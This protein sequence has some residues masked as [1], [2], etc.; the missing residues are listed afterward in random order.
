MPGLD[1]DAIRRTEDAVCRVERTS[2]AERATSLNTIGTV[3]QIV[4]VTS[5]T[6]DGNGRYPGQLQEYSVSGDSWTDLVECR[7]EAIGVTPALGRTAAIRVGDDGTYPVFVAT[8]G[9]GSGGA[10]GGITVEEVDGSPSYAGIGT[11]RFDQTDGFVLS[12]PA[13]GIARVDHA[14]ATDT[15]RGIVNTAVQVYGGRKRFVAD[16]T[17]LSEAGVTATNVQFDDIIDLGASMPWEV[18]ID[19]AEVQTHAGVSF[20]SGAGQEYGFFYQAE[21]H[22]GASWSYTALVLDAYNP[23]TSGERICAYLRTADS[24][25]D[26]PSSSGDDH[27][28]AGFILVGGAY[29]YHDGTD[30]HVGASATASGLVFKAGLY[31]SGSVSITSAGVSDFA[32]AVDDRVAAML[33]AGSNIT[34]T[35][36]DGANTLT[37]ASSGGVADGDK[38]DITVSSSGTV[39]TIDTNVVSDAKFRQSAALSVVGRSVNSVGNVADITASAAYQ[40]LRCNTAGTAIGFGTIDIKE[41]TGSGVLPVQHGGTGVASAT[42]YAVICGGTTSTGAWQ[43]VASVGTSGQVLTS[44][45]AGALPSFQNPATSG[46]VT[47]VNLTA[48]A[49]GITVSG[50]PITTSGSITLALADDLAALEALAGTNNIYYRSAANTWTSVTIGSGLTF[51]G[52]TLSVS[53]ATA[54]KAWVKFAG[55]SGTIAASHNVTSVSRDSAGV[56]TITWDTDFASANYAVFA[57][58][59]ITAG[60]TYGAY[61]GVANGSQ[62]A[63]SVQIKFLD[64]AGGTIDYPNVYVVAFG[65]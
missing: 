40:V 1:I 34:L 50:G 20:G 56:Y 35:Y 2:G 26:S 27:G 54:A 59:E 53:A 24:G 28:E 42:A 13:T 14:D 48:P 11:L 25:G 23:P 12:Q 46:T 8:V 36:D 51:S 58:V 39:W 45:G 10:A 47:S 52:G 62:A 61:D 32:E 29:Q 33:V 65:S 17:D 7:V 31:I 16:G 5:L 37:I 21:V 49:A 55:S 64:G 30:C 4:N 63:G 38:G 3:V 41:A 57:F 22:D 43:S 15:Q 19:D 18:L 6:P 44:N 9:T 60:G